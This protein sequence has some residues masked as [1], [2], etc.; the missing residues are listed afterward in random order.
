MPGELF[1]HPLTVDFPLGRMM[2]DVKP[3]QAGEQLLML[4]PLVFLALS[5]IVIGSRLCRRARSLV[6]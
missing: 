4:H 3:D 6:N 1:D 2:Q 5:N